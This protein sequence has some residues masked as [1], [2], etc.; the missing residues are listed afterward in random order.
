M[1]ALLAIPE[2]QSVDLER[3]HNLAQQITEWAGTTE[4]IPELEDARARVAAIEVYI[5]KRDTQAAAALAAADRRL[6]VRIGELLG[7]AKPGPPESSLASEDSLTPNQRNQFRQMAEH[8][9][10]PDVADAIE[11]GASRSEVLRRIDAAKGKHPAPSPP[12]SRASIAAKVEVAKSMA[13]EGYTSRQI[14]E[15]IGIQAMGPFRQ[16]HGIEVP[17]D[18]VVGKAKHIDADRVIAEATSTLEGVALGLSLISPEDIDPEHLSNQ[19]AP[20][21]GALRQITRF[22][23]SMRG[24]QQ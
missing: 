22:Y 12:K 14:G 4:S 21:G 3:A 19:L 15:A 23:K 17:A 13:A 5:R 6:E 7:A 2:P 20:M 16:R 18:G 8:Q 11:N 1:T 24:V 10:H 9:E